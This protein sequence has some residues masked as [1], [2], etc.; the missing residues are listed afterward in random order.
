[1][2]RQLS[3]SQVIAAIILDCLCNL[4]QSYKTLTALQ[5]CVPVYVKCIKCG[6]LVYRE[7]V[8]FILLSYLYDNYDMTY[9]SV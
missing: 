2:T 8:S 6:K 4:Q 5:T 7:A 1:M 3:T 9:T